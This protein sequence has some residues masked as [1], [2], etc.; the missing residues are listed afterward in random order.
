M[1]T[2]QNLWNRPRLLLKN[3]AMALKAIKNTNI[4]EPD[5]GI[6]C[7]KKKRLTTLIGVHW[8]SQETNIRHNLKM[9]VV[10]PKSM[11]KGS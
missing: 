4:T 6:T 8:I 10:H 1:E 7:I 3:A 9:K 5:A 11:E 2:Q